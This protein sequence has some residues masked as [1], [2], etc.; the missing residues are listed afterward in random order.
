[1][2]DPHSLFTRSQVLLQCGTLSS[3]TARLD[4]PL[5]C[6]KALRSISAPVRSDGA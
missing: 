6:L 5:T 2:F 3:V 1:M 4:V